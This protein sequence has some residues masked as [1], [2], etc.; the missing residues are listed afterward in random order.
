MLNVG[1]EVSRR[2]YGLGAKLRNAEEKEEGGV[3]YR[4]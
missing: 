4:L 1:N 2:R 3:K